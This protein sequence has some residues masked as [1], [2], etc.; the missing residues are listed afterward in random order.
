MLVKEDQAD[1]GLENRKSQK[2]FEKSLDAYRK[3]EKSNAAFDMYFN[4]K[5]S[6][7]RVTEQL[8]GNS[9]DR[10]LALTRMLKDDKNEDFKDQIYYEIAEDYYAGNDFG[11]AEEYYNLSVKNS[12]T[13][14]VQKALSYLKIAD[15][16]F[17]HYSDYVTAKLY[18]DSTALTLP[19]THPLYS[20]IANKAQNLA[21]LQQRYETI[22]LQD[23]LQKFA[24]L[25][26]ADR[27]IALGNY[28]AAL[29]NHLP[30][31]REGFWAFANELAGAGFR[32]VLITIAIFVA[33]TAGFYFLL[34][35]KIA[36]YAA[37]QIPMEA[38]VELG[39]QFYDSFVGGM[40]IDEERTKQLQAFAKKMDFQNKNSTTL[41]LGWLQLE[42][43]CTCI[44]S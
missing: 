42:T 35:P 14:N 30:K 27:P 16:N 9:F 1:Y 20:A 21:Y 34:L 24:K 25:P 5:L 22:N 3:V 10:K 29:E 15:L 26:A 19:K 37:A 40:E 4:A 2:E 33:I 17:K 11:K 13:N 36:E 18:Y 12:T 43:S 8:S 39:K 32:G 38:E 28:F 41:C 31:R 6:R 23:T 7:I 44:L